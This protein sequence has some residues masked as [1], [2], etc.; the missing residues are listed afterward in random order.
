LD[1]QMQR[2]GLRLRWAM[3]QRSPQEGG[4]TLSRQ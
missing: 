1:G 3:Q 4:H 2:R